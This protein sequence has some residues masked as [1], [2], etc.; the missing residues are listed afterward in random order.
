MRR[1]HCESENRKCKK[2]GAQFKNQSGDKEEI[3]Q[4][5]IMQTKGMTKEAAIVKE[6]TFW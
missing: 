4:R 6:R 5:L 2:G 1:G 3:K